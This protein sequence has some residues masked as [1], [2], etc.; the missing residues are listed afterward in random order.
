MKI[1]LLTCLALLMLAPPALAQSG[2][3]HSATVDAA[4]VQLARIGGGFR[5]GSR[6]FGGRPRYGSRGYRGRG[7]GRGIFRSII[8]ALAI[9]YLLHLL[10]TTPGGNIMLLLLIGGMIFL[11]M[12]LRRRTMVRY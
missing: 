4:N 11:F 8:R 1:A 9:G 6:G 3:G 12:R 10:F 5:G 7:R 2:G